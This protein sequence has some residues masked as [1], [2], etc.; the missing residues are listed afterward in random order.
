MDDSKP[1]PSLALD[2]VTRLLGASAFWLVTVFVLFACRSGVSVQGYMPIGDIYLVA[3]LLIAFCLPSA[4]LAFWSN[5]L[6][7]GLSR[8]QSYGVF[9]LLQTALTYAYLWWVSQIPG[10]ELHASPLVLL[11]WVTLPLLM[12]AYPVFFFSHAV[13]IVRLVVIALGVFLVIGSLFM[14]GGLFSPNS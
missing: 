2:F 6:N 8:L 12:A 4:I 14:L 7:P 13:N 11:K 9:A 10:N 5:A 1:G 3:G